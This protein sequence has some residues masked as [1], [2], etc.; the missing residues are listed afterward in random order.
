M[1]SVDYLIPFA[2][3]PLPLPSL[4]LPPLPFPPLPSPPLYSPPMQYINLLMDWADSLINSDSVFPTQMGEWIECEYD[5]KIVYS[6][7]G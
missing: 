1:D 6:E 5:F 7:L 3:P 4:P 2:S